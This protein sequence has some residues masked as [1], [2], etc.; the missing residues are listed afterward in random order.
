[1]KKKIVIVGST[2]NF[3]NFIFKE[4]KKKN[5]VLGI[6][7]KNNKDKLLKRTNKRKIMFSLKN[8]KLF[9]TQ[10]IISIN[11]ISKLFYVSNFENELKSF[12]L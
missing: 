11:Y 9:R 3:G 6:G 12:W 8:I 5:L 2:G 4:L 10:L 1:M 7:K